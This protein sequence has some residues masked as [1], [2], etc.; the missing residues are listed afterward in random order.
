M[1]KRVPALPRPEGFDDPRP[2]CGAA[3]EFAGPE[4]A[5]SK[6]FKSIKTQK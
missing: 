5:N 2:R 4:A 6:G 1:S 3:W